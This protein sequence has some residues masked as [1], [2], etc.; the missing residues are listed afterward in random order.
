MRISS[1]SIKSLFG[2]SSRRQQATS[3]PTVTMARG[4]RGKGKT[5]RNETPSALPQS[6]PALPTSQSDI[7]MPITSSIDSISQ[8]CKNTGSESSA[9][10]A[11]E[12]FEL[13][14]LESSA[15][16]GPRNMKTGFSDS[17]GAQGLAIYS[18]SDGEKSPAQATDD[19]K[20]PAKSKKRS[21]RKAKKASVQGQGLQVPTISP[22]ILPLEYCGPMPAPPT[23]RKDP[24]TASPKPNVGCP[25]VSPPLAFAEPT[26]AEENLRQENEK[27]RQELEEANRLAKGLKESHL[28]L[29]EE[30]EAW[31]QKCEG[32][33]EVVKELRTEVEEM[34]NFRISKF[35]EKMEEEKEKGGKEQEERKK[36][37]REKEG[38]KTE[39]KEREGKEK[40]R[41]EKEGKEKKG[42]AGDRKEEVGK[43]EEAELK[44]RQVKSQKSCFDQMQDYRQRKK[45]EERRSK[46]WWNR[47]Q[48]KLVSSLATQ[49]PMPNYPL[50]CNKKNLHPKAQH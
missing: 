38:E 24:P 4:S 47:F 27:L 30:V 39:R 25:S 35:F 1:A 2:F 11:P 26:K 33:S 3:H 8:D 16:A 32:F 44:A 21:K 14:N 20:F 48:I 49:F 9:L 36:E 42:K 22:E 23:S 17:Q 15:W 12:P 43:A 7:T 19:R 29:E 37:R 50:I 34:I 40:G 18:F 45:A 10:V 31:K 6:S 13:D 41:K 5:P 28:R 46:K